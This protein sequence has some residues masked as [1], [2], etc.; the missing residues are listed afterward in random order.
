MPASLAQPGSPGKSTP[1]SRSL[2]IPSKQGAIDGE[3]DG[4]VLEIIH[5]IA[6][7]AA[8]GFATAFLALA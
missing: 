2:S 4:A 1:P 3:G 7:G 6:P 8:L 5:D